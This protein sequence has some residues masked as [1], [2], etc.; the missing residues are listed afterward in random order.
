MASKNSRIYPK[1]VFD[2]AVAHYV[3]CK[4]LEREILDGLRRLPEKDRDEALAAIKCIVE[5]YTT[6]AKATISRPWPDVK[7]DVDGH[8]LGLSSSSHEKP[9]S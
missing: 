8:V 5:Q 7:I 3:K 6:R 2:K 9:I 4:R 1:S